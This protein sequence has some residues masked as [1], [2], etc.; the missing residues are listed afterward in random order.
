MP[1]DN[2]LDHVTAK[3]LHRFE[4]LEF[5]REDEKEAAE[6]QERLLAPKKS[7]G[8]PKKSQSKTLPAFGGIQDPRNLDNVAQAPTK[9]SRGPP[10]KNP[11]PSFNGPQPLGGAATKPD[12]EGSHSETSSQSSSSYEASRHPQSRPR[13]Y[14]LVVAAGLNRTVDEETT[15][16][17]V[18]PQQETKNARP[19][20]S[21]KR[22]PKTLSKSDSNIRSPPQS[23]YVINESQ[24]STTSQSRSNMSRIQIVLPQKPP[25]VP[26]SSSEVDSDG[27]SALSQRRAALINQFRPARM[28]D[29]SRTPSNTSSRSNSIKRKRKRSES[30]GSNMRNWQ[31]HPSSV[32]AAS[33]PSPNPDELLLNST[34][35]R[36]YTISELFRKP[37]KTKARPRSN[38]YSLFSRS[39]DATF[40]QDMTTNEDPPRSSN[41]VEQPKVGGSNSLNPTPFHAY[42]P[43]PLPV[44][45]QNNDQHLTDAAPAPE[46]SRRLLSSKLSPAP[47]P[48][49]SRRAVSPNL[50]VISDD[51]E[52]NGGDSEEEREEILPSE[53][54]TVR[55]SKVRLT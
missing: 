27:H 20:I 40:D 36:T 7:R 23:R 5:L 11:A 26:S 3:E 12:R 17:D 48:M 52:E 47:K 38:D 50:I 53:S 2:I 8:R 32:L 22:S 10:R 19:V 34:F 39:S 28:R 41:L 35:P 54:I 43:N 45:S 6:E 37:T 30:G 18:S 13:V 9:R 16:R 21:P 1:L 42:T 14:S 44:S 15:S 4:H 51:E 25:S 33:K 55:K 24:G 31:E 29:P 49:I 46:P